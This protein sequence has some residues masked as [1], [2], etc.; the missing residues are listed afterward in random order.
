MRARSLR[1]KR[2]LRLVPMNWPGKRQVSQSAREAA[3]SLRLTIR[4]KALYE[5]ARKGKAMSRYSIVVCS[6]NAI[7]DRG[8]LCG[9]Y[10]EAD[11][12]QH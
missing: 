1:S 9:D 11:G 4:R 7:N 2:G 12:T 3:K 10:L 8:M 5:D 6:I